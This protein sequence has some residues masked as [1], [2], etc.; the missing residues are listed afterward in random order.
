MA[1]AIGLVASIFAVVQIA[2]RIVKA[3]KYYIETTEDY[4]RDLRLIY[5]EIGSLKV[6]FEGLTF[7]SHEDAA[8]SLTL[9]AVLG[10]DGPVQHCKKAIEDLEKLF[11]SVPS[12]PASTRKKG[13]R[14]RLQAC[15][16]SLAWPLK[17]EKSRKLLEE[18]MK[19]KSTI[20]VALQGQLL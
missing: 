4:P 19:Y 1:E 8:D 10:S 18:I 12:T 16:D 15:L 5:V 9:K 2:D 20:S 6:I 14:K 7:L 17:A 3:C 11:P 13:K